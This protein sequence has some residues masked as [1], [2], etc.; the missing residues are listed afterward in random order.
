MIDRCLIPTR[1]NWFTA[2]MCHVLILSIVF[3]FVSIGIQVHVS[4]KEVSRASD[5]FLLSSRDMPLAHL[6]STTSNSSARS[7]LHR[8]KSG[9]ST[10]STYGDDQSTSFAPD[11]SASRRYIW[12]R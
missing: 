1:Q 4:Y 11:G 9:Q 5:S 12:K 7:S 6:I 8:G 2:I 3:L 10:I